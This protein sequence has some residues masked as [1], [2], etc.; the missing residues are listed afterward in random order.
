M[1]LLQDRRKEGS[2]TRVVTIGGG[3]EYLGSGH[4]LKVDFIGFAGRFKT[5]IIPG[6][7]LEDLDG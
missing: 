5:R 2:W 4:I 7:G 3:K 1:R 6:S